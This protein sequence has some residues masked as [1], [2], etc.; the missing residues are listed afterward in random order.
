MVIEEETY[1]VM[2]SPIHGE[3]NG[4]GYNSVLHYICK[5]QPCL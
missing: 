5:V 4:A 1:P 2:D 3:Y